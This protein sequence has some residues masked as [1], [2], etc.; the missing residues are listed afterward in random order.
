MKVQ[1]FG[2][3]HPQSM[4]DFLR[5]FQAVQQWCQSSAAQVD[6]SQSSID[7]EEPSTSSRNQHGDGLTAL[8]QQFLSAVA[9]LQRSGE[10]RDKAVTIAAKRLEEVSG[11]PQAKVIEIAKAA[12]EV[13]RLQASAYTHMGPA[14]EDS[15]DSESSEA[16]SEAEYSDG[17]ER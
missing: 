9:R 5:S 4:D 3:V 7:S 12:L 15:D 2:L 8:Q 6:T 13:Q 14:Q 16:A 17:G 11:M 10:P 1:D